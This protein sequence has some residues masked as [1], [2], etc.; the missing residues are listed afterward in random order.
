MLSDNGPPFASTGLGRL[1][2]LGVW[3][4]RLDVM[5]VFIEPGRPDQNGRHERFHETLQADAASP[6]RATVRAQQTAF[7]YFQTEYNEER[8]HEA[9][10]MKVPGEVY[11][12]SSRQMPAVLPEHEYP[13]SFEVRR[14]R[15]DGS[16][17]WAGRML[18]IGEALSGEHVGIEQVDDR[19][20]W[21]LRGEPPTRRSAPRLRLA[22]KHP[23]GIVSSSGQVR[24]VT[25]VPGQECYPCPRL[26][27]LD[28]SGCMW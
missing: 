17:K 27:I 26:H 6:P 8:P 12:L 20:R 15:P 25:H 23:G 5:P 11:E 24:S 28:S 16:M 1:S 3:L 22:P 14:V 2:R 10:G 21:V 13:A 18:F 9:L 4:L 19:V 7:T